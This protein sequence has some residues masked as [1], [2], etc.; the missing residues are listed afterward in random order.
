MS[1]DAAPPRAPSLAKAPRLRP[2]R[3]SPSRSRPGRVAFPA[4]PLAEASRL[5]P[6]RGSPPRSRPGRAALPSTPLAEASRLRPPRDS[7]S[8]SRRQESGFSPSRGERERVEASCG[9]AFVASGDDAT[10]L[11]AGPPRRSERG[12]ASCGAALVASGDDATPLSAGPPRRVGASCG[13]AFVAF[14]D[15]AP[16]RPLPL[17]R[18]RERPPCVS[19]S[20]AGAEGAASGAARRTW[21]AL[22]P[23]PSG[24]RERGLRPPSRSAGAADD[25]DE[26]ALAAEASGFFKNR[27]TRPRN[28]LLP[29]SIAQSAS[30]TASAQRPFAPSFPRKREISHPPRPCSTPIAPSFPRRRESRIPSPYKRPLHNSVSARNS[31]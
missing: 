29:H 18:R 13:V 4:T 28:I 12:E 23:V 15:D 24:V 25:G 14:G 5:R 2:P 19:P 17:R 8:R 31:S 20:P 6:P 9:A 11:S 27:D 22:A 10:P 26:D 7:P 3:G 21:G 30:H 16:P 1:R